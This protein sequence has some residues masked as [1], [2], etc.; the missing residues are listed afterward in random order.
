[1][2]DVAK[3]RGRMAELRVTQK[4]IAKELNLA[5]PTAS[6]KTQPDS[7]AELG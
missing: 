4:D 3:I 1:M 2:I 7:S 6:Q 5:A